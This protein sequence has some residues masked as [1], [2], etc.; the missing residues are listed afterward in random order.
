M[1]ENST[2]E[3]VSFP[4]AEHPRKTILSTIFILGLALTLHLLYGPLYGIFTILILWLSLLPYYS[5][6]TY[7]LDKDGIVIKKVFYT[8]RKNW[9]QYRSF[10]PDR[11]GVLLSPFPVP[12]RLENF[13][14]L[15]IRFSNNRDEAIAFI[16]SRLGT[17]DENTTDG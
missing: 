16:E 5:Q 13:R 8:I 7:L 2:I 17:A 9:S 15:F 3:W 12:S 14:G 11:N 1:A 10:Y 6:T 4:A